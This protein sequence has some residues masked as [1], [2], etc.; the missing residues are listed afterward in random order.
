MIRSL[1]KD[2]VARAGYEIR[3]PTHIESGASMPYSRLPKFLYLNRMFDLVRD[4]EGDVVECGVGR[5][6]SFIMFAFL[7]QD[8][9]RGRK[10][11]GFDS[12]EGFQEPDEK[13]Q[14]IRR[15]KRGDYG[16]TS[17]V[18]LQTLLHNSGLSKEFVK[19]QITIVG[20]FF[21]ESLSKY[22]G[23]KVALLHIDADLYDSYTQVLETLYP[24]VTRGGV[25]M[26]DEYM[27][28]SENLKWPGAQKAIDEFF[29]Y[30][31]EKPRRDNTSGKYYII[32]P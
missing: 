31:Q 16:D 6:N 14:S 4:M 5:G 8:E 30:R 28:T 1:I 26:F 25:V 19:S 3:R 18:A 12:F 23:E 17:I 9:M 20:G 10:L 11:W 22:R 24:K 13:D 7:I 15:A 32:K 29:K 27:G 2:A 21:E